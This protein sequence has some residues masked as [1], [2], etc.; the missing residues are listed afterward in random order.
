MQG[1]TKGKKSHDAEKNSKNCVIVQVET[2]LGNWQGL[3]GRFVDEVKAA[4]GVS[5]QVRGKTSARRYL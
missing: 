3:G 2:V 4:V 1:T 5:C